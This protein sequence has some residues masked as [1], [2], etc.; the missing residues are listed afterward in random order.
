MIRHFRCSNSPCRDLW[1]KGTVTIGPRRE[2][3]ANP[4]YEAG[5]TDWRRA[6]EFAEYTSASLMTRGLHTWRYG[7]FEMRQPHY[8]LVNLA[9]GGTSGGDPSHTTF[10]ARYEIDYYQK[11]G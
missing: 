2:R 5:S 4:R 7:Y 10:P 8:M 3:R 9:I 6:R 11:S 1:P